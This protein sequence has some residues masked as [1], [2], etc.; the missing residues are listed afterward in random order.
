MKIGITYDLRDDYL[1]EGYSE[2]E[3]AEFDRPETIDA[4]ERTLCDLGFATDRIGNI[5]RLA[6]RLARGDRWNLVFNIAEGMRGVGREAQVPCLLEAYDIPYTFSDPLVLSL[7]LHKGMCKQVV[8]SLGIPTPDFC[9]VETEADLA[10]VNLP[11]PLFAKP[12]GE[13]TG[14]GIDPTSKIRSPQ[15]LL[16]AGRRLLAQFNQPVLVET[17]LPG[18]EFTVG[19]LGAG[20]EARAVGAMEIHLKAEAENDVY[21]YKNKE[22]C[23]ELVDYSWADDEMAKQCQEIALQAWRGLGCLDGGRV[24]LRADA[25]GVP[26]FMEVNP[27]AGLHPEHS[28]L[29]ILCA[30]AGITYQ[31]LIGTIV[32]SAWKRALAARPAHRIEIA[33]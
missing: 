21:S 14:K 5:R 20:E 22:Y 19:I 33:S 30:K 32:Q 10:R 16:A 17:F 25:N 12:I 24:D 15:E 7:T 31:K 26:N 13:G 8:R 28:D 9:V 6:E 3:T 1:A 23:E 18:R 4:L 11:Y 27:L 29:P 2:E